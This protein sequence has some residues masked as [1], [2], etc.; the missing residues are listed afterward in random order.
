M[1]QGSLESS[2]ICRDRVTL[3]QC[4][5]WSL[6]IQPLYFCERFTC[7]Q[8]ITV[9]HLRCWIRINSLK[10][11]SF[12]ENAFQVWK[13][14]HEESSRFLEFFRFF[15]Q[16]NISRQYINFDK[17]CVIKHVLYFI[18]LN[19]QSWNSALFKW[20]SLKSVPAWIKNFDKK[21]TMTK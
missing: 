1:L 4:D 21:Q 7:S 9:V 10:L 20:N 3:R 11:S 18:V 16:K 5:Q 2:V 15:T 12:H 8:W 19:R 17:A 13:S 6:R 14:H